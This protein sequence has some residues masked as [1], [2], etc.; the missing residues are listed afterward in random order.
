MIGENVDQ[1]ELT[2]TTGTK[3]TWHNHFEKI[4]WHYLLNLNIS[5][6]TSYIPRN[7][8][9][10]ALREMYENVHSSITCNSQKVQSKC[11]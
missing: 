8:H 6:A 10:C 1:C 7:V 5:N 9:V 4:I 11:L 3:K 2:Y